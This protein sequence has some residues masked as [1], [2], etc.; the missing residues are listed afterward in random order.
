MEVIETY[1]CWKMRCMKG[2]KD[3][4][5]K[6]GVGLANNAEADL[7]CQ[8]K[9]HPSS[10]INHDTICIERCKKK[11][12]MLGKC[13]EKCNYII[14]GKKVTRRRLRLFLKCWRNVVKPCVAKEIEA[15]CKP[16][17]TRCYEVEMDYCLEACK[18]IKNDAEQNK[19][20]EGC[21]EYKCDH[22]KPKYK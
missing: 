16:V 10:L 11:V 3:P 4:C 12:E 15:K 9:C 19:C 1:D 21:G 17:V 14:Q 2:P 8:N 18:L 7:K 13:K 20:K 22:V 5:R 6:I